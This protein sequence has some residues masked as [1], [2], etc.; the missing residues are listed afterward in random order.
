MKKIFTLIA[1]IALTS[2]AANAQRIK[3]ITFEGVT[4]LSKCGYANPTATVAGTLEMIFPA[5]TDF[6]NM[7]ATFVTDATS[8][9]TT[10]PVPTNFTTVQSVALATTDGAKS[11]SYNVNF[12]AIAPASLPLNV[13]FTAEN[14]PVWTADTKGWAG[15]CIDEAK[16]TIVLSNENRGF[17]LA[18]TD[19]P[20]KFSFELNRDSN[21]WNDTNIFDV[22]QSADGLTWTSVKQYT[23]A[24]AVVD[25]PTAKEEFALN[26][27]TRFIRLNYTKRSAA[28]G[29]KATNVYINK[30]NI[31][32]SE[33]TNT[34]IS[35]EELSSAKAFVALGTKTLVVTNAAEIAKLQVVNMVGQTVVSVAQP[36]NNIALDQ[37]SEGVYLV[38][39]ILNT[40]KTTLSKVIVK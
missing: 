5:G 13:E 38:K 6:S 35:N 33:K 17:V 34:A 10:K 20:D 27:S 26:Y 8:A 36:S 7:K 28:A 12:R 24:N 22:E 39:M 18:F 32:K 31:T 11:A 15:T 16:A 1:A 37:L 25:K 23:G 2:T 30:F 29:A 40:G 14:K 4:A 21:P 19:A 9:I 3:D